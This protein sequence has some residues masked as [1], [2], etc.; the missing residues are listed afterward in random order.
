MEGL[1][2]LGILME[3][4]HEENGFVFVTLLIIWYCSNVLTEQIQLL[5]LRSVIKAEVVIGALNFKLL[6]FSR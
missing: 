6:F 5:F 4:F 1:Y 2:L 3:Y